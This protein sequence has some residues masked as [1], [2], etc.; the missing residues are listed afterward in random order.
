MRNYQSLESITPQ[1]SW[2]PKKVAGP[3][4]SLGAGASSALGAALVLSRNARTAS[5]A[6]LASFG[7]RLDPKIRIKIAKMISSSVVPSP[8]ICLHL[9]VLAIADGSSK[10][11]IK[12]W[13][14]LR[15]E[16][17]LSCSLEE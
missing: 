9:W 4:H 16:Q 13:L 10:K 2:G 7:S 15:F 12:R 1:V 11:L 8:N 17:S 5:P 6:D 14:T 3:G